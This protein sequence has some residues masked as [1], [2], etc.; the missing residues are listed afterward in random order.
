MSAVDES[1]DLVDIEAEIRRVDGVIG[2]VIF[3][4]SKGNPREVQAF[5]RA[6]ISERRVRQAIAEALAQH[7]KMQTTERVY[8]F[9]LTGEEFPLAAA[10]PESGHPSAAGAQTVVTA[11]APLQAGSTGPV[12]ARIGRIMLT[13]SG[14]RPVANVRLILGGKEA[15]GSGRG[16]DA[17]D[18][19]RVTAATTLEAAQALI[20][21]KGIFELEGVELVDA[22]G[23]QVVVVLVQSAL[24]G[25]R[26]LLGACLRCDAPVHEAVVRAT[27]DAV[28]RQLESALTR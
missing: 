1:A 25:E 21:Q 4:D 15:E 22:V 9:E 24:G 26:R 2:A 11:S 18:P 3:H 19:L 28:N 7:H 20:G 5:T 16:I 14:A 12:R 10:S 6:G 13:A 17:Q 27:L 23:E 8:V